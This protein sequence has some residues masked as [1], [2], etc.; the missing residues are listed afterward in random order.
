MWNHFAL[1]RRTKTSLKF[2]IV[3]IFLRSSNSPRKNTGL[4]E[5]MY[6]EQSYYV[7]LTKSF[8]TFFNRCI[9]LKHG[10]LSGLA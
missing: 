9:F 6:W 2:I 3:A 4:Q 10:L 8:K 1:Y 5:I 7:I